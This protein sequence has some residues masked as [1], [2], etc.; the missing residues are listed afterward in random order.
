MTISSV[1]S[2][3][4]RRSDS[5]AHRSFRQ[6]RSTLAYPADTQSPLTLIKISEIDNRLL[7]TYR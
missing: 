7:S 2:V 6:G 1:R 4:K 3:E 5:G